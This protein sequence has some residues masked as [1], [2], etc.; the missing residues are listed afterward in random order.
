VF[1]LICRLDLEGVV[2]KH[3]SGL[4]LPFAKLRKIKIK[5]PKYT[6]A[7]GRHE[8]FESMRSA[9]FSRFAF[10]HIGRF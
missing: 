10:R 4:H 5:N 7:E 3:K 9:R 1:E 6:Q 2:A 8:L